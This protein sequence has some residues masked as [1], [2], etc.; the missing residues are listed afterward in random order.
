MKHRKPEGDT[1]KGVKPHGASV[2]NGTKK[3]KRFPA[4]AQ[5]CN[6][7]NRLGERCQQWL[8]KGTKK[9]R[10]HGS[11]GDRTNRGR[12]IK[13]GLYSMR[14]KAITEQSQADRLAE[15]TEDPRLLDMARTIATSQAILEEH[16]PALTDEAIEELWRRKN[17]PPP[18]VTPGDGEEGEKGWGPS[19]GELL[20]LKASL[21]KT[22]IQALSLHGNMQASARRTLATE[23]LIAT[24]VVPVLTKLGA[25]FMDVV[26]AHVTK[27][28]L[29]RIRT[30]L[31]LKHKRAVLDVQSALIERS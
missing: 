16:L 27:D 23:Q 20:E 5:R 31:E 11:G 18:G 19:P 24:M 6:A 30:S 29:E 26:A 15:L 9:C 21:V 25:E 3:P 13:H 14:L 10:H 7:V 22:T 8:V 2:T 12:P 17:P 4:D 28:Q 1:T